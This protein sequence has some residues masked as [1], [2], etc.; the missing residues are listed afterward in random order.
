[1]FASCVPALIS[2]LLARRL[3]PES[4]RFTM[5]V[6]GN[7]QEARNAVVKA[8]GFP[9][10]KDAPVRVDVQYTWPTFWD[11]FSQ[12]AIGLMWLWASAGFASSA[13]EAFLVGWAC[14]PA[15]LLALLAQP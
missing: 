11:K 7:R 12:S 10:D 6:L 9:V 2:W 1:M 3:L 15:A 14:R 4:P 5:M 13:L 8:L